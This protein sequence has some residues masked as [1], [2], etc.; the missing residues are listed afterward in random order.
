VVRVHD[1]G[2]HAD[3]GPYIVME[4]LDG[5]SLGQLLDRTTVLSPAETSLVVAQTA[6]ALDAAHKAGVVHRDIKPDNVFITATDDGPLVKV[7]DFGLAKQPR[8]LP[9]AQRTAAGMVVGTPEFMSPEQL[10]NAAEVDAQA[11]RWSLAVVAYLCLTGGLP[12]TGS[13][14]GE[15]CKRLLDGRFAPPSASRPELGAAVDRWFERALA[16]EP[17]QRFGSAREL[18]ITLAEALQ[19]SAVAAE[20]A[21]AIDAAHTFSGSSADRR[22][23]PHWGSSWSIRAIGAIAASAVV[24][25]AAAAYYR[26]ANPRVAGVLAPAF[27]ALSMAPRPEADHEAPLPGAATAVPDL[28]AAPSG[29]APRVRPAARPR[30]RHPGF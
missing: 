1:S 14:L 12:F 3:A 22:P 4:L 16:P 21:P 7:L 6:K 25:L 19:G 17:A 5:E 9:L 10:L 24:V 2:V 30:K 27:G 20:P 28:T 8:P 29:T 23:V 11:D 13:H 26:H 18:A 15:L